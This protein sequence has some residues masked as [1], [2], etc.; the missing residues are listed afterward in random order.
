MSI[1]PSISKLKV[2]IQI[3]ILASCFLVGCAQATINTPT[4]PIQALSDT[5]TA[6]PSSTLTPTP[7]F[8]PTP[9]DI[10]FQRFV[11]Y[12]DSSLAIGDAGDNIVHVRFS[13]VTNLESLMD[14]SYTL[15]TANFGGRTAKWDYE[16]LEDNL[17]SYQSDGVTLWWGFDDMGGCL[18]AF[19][20]ATNQMVVYKAYAI[21]DEHI[22]YLGLQIDT[23]LA[24]NL[25]VIVLTPIPANG[26]L[27][28]SSLDENNAIV[29]D[30][31]HW[32]NFNLALQLLVQAQRELVMQY[33]SRDEPV[34]LV[35]VWKLYMDHPDT[36]KMYMDVVHPASNGAKLIAEE[37]L[38]LFESIRR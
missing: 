11:F 20:R 18:G 17:L 5:S 6:I 36:E 35:D 19:D 25:P 31:S 28:W 29:W 14:P 22:H 10:T 4:L 26:F 9:T 24:Q 38:R 33:E 1:S 21:I 16:H 15:I 7:T 8:S 23:L 27:Q 13:F 32:C 37:W 2:Y 3:P 12:G 30:D 34:Y